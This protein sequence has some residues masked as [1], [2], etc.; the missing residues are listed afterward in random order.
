MQDLYITISDCQATNEGRLGDRNLILL[1]L[2][3]SILA[4]TRSAP[5]RWRRRCGNKSPRAGGG[6]AVGGC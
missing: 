4:K 1:Y 2:T 6:R 5:A 3:R